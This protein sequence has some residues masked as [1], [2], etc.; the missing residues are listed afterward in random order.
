MK[1]RNQILPLVALAGL[2]LAASASAATI[3]GTGFSVDAI[4]EAGA[5][6][7]ADGAPYAGFARWVLAEAGA[8]NSA[9][10]GV[11]LIAGGLITTQF[12]TQFQLEPYT[13]ANTLVNGDTF[14][15]T[16][17]GS[18]SDLQ[19]F[20]TGIGGGNPNNFQATVN[21]SDAS[22]T[23]LSFGVADWQSSQAYNAFAEKTD[24]VRRGSTQNLALWTRE[25]DFSLSAGDQAKTVT[26]IDFALADRLGL[27]A[28]SGTAVAVPE[29]S[30]FILI[31]L[32]GLT[33]L[34]RRRA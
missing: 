30:S 4:V 13:A 7:V 8:P 27:S 21:F 25:L 15:L 11:P 31:G 18:F 17:P 32:S 23:L 16:T 12:G 6:T 28:V 2:S 1:T 10:A 22:T 26:S 24:F 34:R 20:V 9:P 29:P 5:V 14:T 3:S 33:L 19:F